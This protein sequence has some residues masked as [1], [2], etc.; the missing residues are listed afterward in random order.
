MTRQ[1]GTRK[2][3]LPSPGYSQGGE[4]AEQD[5]M[6]SGLPQVVRQ[7]SQAKALSL[8]LGHSSNPDKV[9]SNQANFVKYVNSIETHFGRGRTGD[10][11]CD[12]S[13]QS[14]FE[15]IG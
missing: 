9:V 3:L 13:V 4:W 11:R 12:M 6:I 8:S 14:K 15:P 10:Y 5:K 1:A 7:S 2:E